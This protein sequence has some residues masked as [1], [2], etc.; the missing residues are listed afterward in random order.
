MSLEHQTVSHEEALRLIDERI[1]E[2]VHLALFLP[3]VDGDAPG[4]TDGKTMFVG[5][6][7]RL[8]NPLEP[9][10]PRL[11]PDVG[12]Y[13]FGR[14]GSDT[15]PFA[16]IA[17]SIELRDSGLNFH[18]RGGGLIRLAWRGSAEV[19]HGPDVGTLTRLRLMGV[20]SQDESRE[21]DASV[22]LRRFLHK[23]PRAPADVLSARPTERRND[24]TGQRIWSLRLRV[25]PGGGDPFEASTE[26]LW[27]A[28]E[29]IDARLARGETLSCLP[30]ERAEIDVAYDPERPE[31]VMAYPDTP[32]DPTTIPLRIGVV[33]KTIAE[34]SPDPER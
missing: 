15:Y 10:P 19:G 29:E 34:E 13:G 7:G 1:G 17:E 26:V 28:N 25:R 11:E 3:S 24:K 14:D 5:R 22:E 33:G 4:M 16:P 27:A 18:L 6:S 2:R 23:A 30:T 31:E 32:A 20:A 21:D 12:F 8:V 9:R